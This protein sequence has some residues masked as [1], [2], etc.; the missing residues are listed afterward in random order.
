MTESDLNIISSKVIEAAIIVHNELGPGLFES[1]YARCLRRELERMGIA[2][3]SEV[4]VPI[5]YRG[6]KV[7]DEGFRIDLLVE[8]ALVVELKSIE[9]LQPVHKKQ[10]LTY[11]RL[12]GKTLG[13]IINFNQVRI[14]DGISR[15]I[16]TA[17]VQ[18]CDSISAVSEIESDKYH[19]AISAASSDPAELGNGRE[20]DKSS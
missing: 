5:M 20:T 19:S 3:Q 4:P 1:V 17:H 16:S 15:V 14:K 7:A 9:Q 2:V 13:L 18:S 12:T 8:D 11:L 6:E 10:L